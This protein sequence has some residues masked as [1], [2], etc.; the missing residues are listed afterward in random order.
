MELQKLIQVFLYKNK[1]ARISMKTFKRR[2]YKGKL[3]P[4]DNKIHYKA[5]VSKCDS[6]S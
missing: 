4:P 6:G 5:S 3:D 1:D 2:N